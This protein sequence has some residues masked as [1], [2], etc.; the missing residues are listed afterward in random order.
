M[1]GYQSG[2][3]VVVHN[4]TALPFTLPDGIN[5]PTGYTTYIGIKRK[6]TNK[7]S[8]PYSNCLTELRAQNSYAKTLFGYFADLNVT[9]YDQN[10]CYTLCFQDHLVNRCACSDISTPAIRNSNYCMNT[11]EIEC[12]YNFDSFF[13]STDID[14]LCKSA[15]PEKCSTIEYDLVTNSIATFP[16]LTYLKNQQAGNW[17][18]YM[19]PNGSDTE[20][21]EFGRTGFLKVIVNYDNLYYTLIQEIPTTTQS[22]LFGYLGINHVK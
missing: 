6:F 16:T 21:I 10:L 13:T 14:L 7:L 3:Y 19:F 2:I 18:H 5:I 20:L 15:C 8:S 11:S 9:Y 17:S 12:L 1:L 4:Q 22:T